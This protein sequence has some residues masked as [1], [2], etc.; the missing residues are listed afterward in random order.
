MKSR[1]TMLAGSPE[2]G[3]MV[4][5]VYSLLGDLIRRRSDGTLDDH[6][7]WQAELPEWLTRRF[8]RELSDEER[9]DWLA[10]WR[11]ASPADKAA[12][13]E[14]RGWELRQWLYWFSAGNDLWTIDDVV[15][16]PT[17]QELSIVIRHVDDPVPV[18]ALQWLASAAGITFGEVSRIQ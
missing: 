2:G 17:G 6:E 10:R 16:S 14:S 9:Q 15:L 7:R 3:R 8:S 5:S 1:I 4:A 12:L 18:R 13:E 11:S